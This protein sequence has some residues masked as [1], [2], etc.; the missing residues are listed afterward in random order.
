MTS[1]MVVMSVWRLQ[2]VPVGAEKP[3]L[4]GDFAC[5]HPSKVFA[6][7]RRVAADSAGVSA[8]S[9]APQTTFQPRI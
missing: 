5:N 8:H 2:V 6:P 7:P 3:G 9:G 4:H 1:A